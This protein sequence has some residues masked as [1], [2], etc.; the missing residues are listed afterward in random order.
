MLR[1]GSMTPGVL[2]LNFVLRVLI[3]L[4]FP[5]EYSMQW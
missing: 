2:L 5:A 1:L 4:E 3:V